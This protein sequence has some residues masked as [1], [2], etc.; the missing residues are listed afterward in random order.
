MKRTTRAFTMVELM[1]AVSLLVIVIAAT[2]RIFSTASKV[3]A[4]GEANTS[5]LQET[6]AIERQIRSDLSRLDYD[7]VLVVQCVA[8]ANNYNQ[9]TNAT[10]PLIDPSRPATAIIRC[11][12][13]AFFAK[14]TQDSARFMGGQDLGTGNGLARSGSSR[15]LYGHG[16]QLPDLIPEGATGTSRPDPIGFDDGPLVPWSYDSVA[17]GPSLDYGYWIGAGGGRTNGTQPEARDWTLA[18]QAVLLADDGGLKTI[19]HQSTPAYGPN[20]ATSL[21]NQANLYQSLSDMQLTPHP[22]VMNNRVDVV[23]TNLDDLRRILAPALS[24]N[25]RQRIINGFFGATAS[26]GQV[27][28]YIRSEKRAPS[29]NRQDV[30]LTSSTLASNCSG[31]MVDWTWSD[32]VGATVVSTPAGTSAFAGFTQ[33]PLF[34]TQWFGFPDSEIPPAQ[35]DER[36]GVMTLTEFRDNYTDSSGNPAFVQIPIRAE[37]IE[38]VPISGTVPVVAPFGAARPLE[39]YTAV[40]GFSGENAFF[41][42]PAGIVP[43]PDYTPWP[44]AL[45]I[46]M[47]LNDPG[48]HLEQGRTVQLIV[49]LPRRPVS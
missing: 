24:A 34:A 43:N 32:G 31:F 28:G 21:F 41:K 35:A 7:G 3:A 30:M 26:Y 23:S 46:T 4:I 47:T 17:D 22:D 40:F 45:R 42:T 14:G 33:P 27:G 16:T 11:D 9:T 39:I 37:A 2:S 20:A 8:V 44:T 12:Q 49:E 29:M 6:A 1:V 5:V 48:K 13:L 25:S 36:R 38:G 18:R 15:V 19:F 10:A